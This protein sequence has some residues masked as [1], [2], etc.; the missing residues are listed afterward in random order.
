MSTIV[1]LTD[2]AFHIYESHNVFCTLVIGT[3]RAL[4][5]DTGFGCRDVMA[6]VRSLTGLPLVV[7]HTHAHLDHAFPYASVPEVRVHRDD[8]ALYKAN[9]GAL[10]KL[11]NILWNPIKADRD[12]MGAYSRNYA[13]KRPRV[14]ELADGDAIDLGDTVLK[15]ISTPGHTKGSVCFLDE[16]NKLLYCGDSVSN[17]VW[18]CLKE[19]T[20]VAAYA[21]G[22]ERLRTF[23][24]DS[25][26]IVASHSEEPLNAVVLDRLIACARRVDPA[27]SAK[28]RNW[29]CKN[30]YVYS[31][32]LD[33]LTERYGITSFDEMVANLSRIDKDIFRN[34]EFVSVVFRK[35]KL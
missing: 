3:K 14:N 33:V 30:S 34:G 11:V 13:K 21:A 4:L 16:R 6:D 24:D 26:R 31:E 25:Y 19:S 15:V 7:A 9:T 5:I 8:V 12:E 20:T 28:Y 17:H 2:S 27:K 10:I 35:D 18:V 1:K 29:Y 22:L 32:G 23:I